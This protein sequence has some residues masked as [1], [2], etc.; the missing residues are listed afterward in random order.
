LLAG[1]GGGGDAPGGGGG[2]VAMRTAQLLVRLSSCLFSFFT[3]FRSALAE[4]AARV[5]SPTLPAALPGPSS[6]MSVVGWGGLSSGGGGKAAGGGGASTLTWA[7]R[8]E[9]F[10]RPPGASGG[11][12]G[13]QNAHVLHRHRSQWSEPYRGLH[14]LSQRA[15]DESVISCG[16]HAIGVTFGTAAAAT[17]KPHGAHAHDLQCAD[18]CASL[19]QCSH[20]ADGFGTPS[21]LVVPADAPTNV[22]EPS[23]R[24]AWWAGPPAVCV[25]PPPAPS[26]SA[27]PAEATAPAAALRSLRRQGAPRSA[28]HATPEARITDGQQ[29]A[30]VVSSPRKRL[31]HWSGCDKHEVE[32]GVVSSGWVW[33][34]GGARARDAQGRMSGAAGRCGGGRGGCTRSAC[35]AVGLAIVPRRRG[36]Y[37]LSALAAALPTSLG[38]AHSTVC[39]AIA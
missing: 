20:L 18:A 7:A 6:I 9:C 13:A 38:A 31:V 5:S 26:R 14:H 10:G 8:C 22:T 16:L 11:E 33:S 28:V 34:M 12:G 35:A 19:H 36:A 30:R 21:Q 1:A 29:V 17:Q 2:E 27:P 32:V 37:C 3:A 24:G 23:A 39:D 15:V 4:L 25:C